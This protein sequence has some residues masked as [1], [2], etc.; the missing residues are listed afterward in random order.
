M[1]NKNLSSLLLAGLC[2][3]STWIWV[4]KIVV[5]YQQTESA[6]RDQPRGNLSDLYPRWLGARELLLRHRDPY[7]PDITR[8]IQTGYYG[9]PLDPTRPNDPKDQQA[10]AYPVYVVLMLAPT[11]GLSFS[12][13][14][15]MA[16]WLLSILIAVSVHLWLRA[17]AW[18]ISGTAFVIWLLLTM[19]SVPAIQALKLQ[20]LTVLVAALLAGSL[21][22]LAR[23]Y[24]G[25]AGVLLAFAT[26][27]PQLVYLLILWLCLWVLGNWRER[28]RLLWSFAV[29]MAILVAAGEMLL[30]GWIT[31]FRAAVRAY[32]QYTGGGKS[33]LDMVLPST[34]ATL[35]SAALVSIFLYLTWRTRCASQD[36]EKFQ[37]AIS[38]ALAT[39]LL[40]VP[41]FAPYNQLLLIPCVMFIGRSL[42]TI[43]SKSRP[44]RIFL[45]FVGTVVFEQWLAAFLLAAALIFLPAATVQ[46]AWALPFYSSPVIP[47]VIYAQL[48]LLSPAVLASRAATQNSLAD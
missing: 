30:P 8:E 27:K 5:P 12:T 15:W 1:M 20:Q 14:H 18:K 47:V 43:W 26:I 29:T 46:R 6:A 9:R 40:L 17:L 13:V 33:V 28:Q 25:F 24:L 48:L 39:T 41:T 2:A 21:Y 22:A 42:R 45:V 23:G 44:S 35:L 31:E 3:V 11:V 4:Q 7:G 34:A 19:G 37:W 36:T 32:Y 38:F 10:F 16:F